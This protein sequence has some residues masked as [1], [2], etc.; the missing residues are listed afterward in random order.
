M[1]KLVLM[2]SLLAFTPPAIAASQT[3]SPPTTAL[4]AAEVIARCAQAMGGPGGIDRLKTLRIGAIWPDHGDN[5]LY[6][7]IRRPNMSYSPQSLMAFDG[8]RACLLKGSDHNSEPQLIDPGDLVDFDVEVGYYFPAF[9]D[10]PT[11]YLGT[12]TVDGRLV[13]KIR[14][15]L[16]HGADLVYLIDAATWLPYKA[17]VRMTMR[18]RAIEAER[19]FSDYRNVDGILYPHGFTYPS[20]DRK[21]ALQGRVTSVK[22]NPALDEAHFTI[23]KDV[24]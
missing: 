12:E 23:P 11:D 6:I 2:F 22:V 21:S 1:K 13:H 10:F 20:R 15:K 8:R 17:N 24:R 4:T 14:P 3:T 7:E 19:V 18:G 5:A 9:F 16:P